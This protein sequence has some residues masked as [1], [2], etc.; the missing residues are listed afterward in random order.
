MEI[1]KH[2]DQLIWLAGENLAYNSEIT[3]SEGCQ[4]L[5]FCDGAIDEVLFP[6]TKKVNLKSFLGKAVGKKWDVYGV[7]TSEMLDLPW[8]CRVNYKESEYDIVVTIKA[9]GVCNVSIEDGGKLYRNFASSDLNGITKTLLQDKF[10]PVI[11]AEAQSAISRV[12]N[13]YMDFTR[14][15]ESKS[16]I[17][18]SIKSSLNSR[19]NN[20]YGLRMHE[21]LVRIHEF[22]G[23]QEIQELR[24]QEAQTN[25]RR[26]IDQNTGESLR[27]IGEG[28][29]A[30]NGNNKPK[31]PVK[32][33]I[34]IFVKKDG[35]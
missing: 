28:L 29:H 33:R 25:I 22:E 10:R 8:G 21:V 4:A 14:I 7:N 13:E 9:A 2:L 31:E 26:R 16:T 6:G 23:L 11:V 3:V 15:E 20:I 19:L 27:A 32:D 12:A 5:V 24:Q 35:E 18:N 30:L 1:K 34:N 17:A